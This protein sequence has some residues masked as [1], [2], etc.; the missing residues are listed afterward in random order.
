MCSEG[1]RL[2][3][4]QAWQRV[5]CGSGFPVLKWRLHSDTVF[6]C[7]SGEPEVSSLGPGGGAGGPGSVTSGGNG[8]SEAHA[9]PRIFVG[10]LTK[11]TTEDDVKQYF[12]RCALIQQARGI[13]STTLS[14]PAVAF[15]RAQMN[16]AGA[17]GSPGMPQHTLLILPNMGPPLFQLDSMQ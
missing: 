8:P 4:E 5:R 15:G 16:S 6:G 9:G 3:Q 12:T 7:L 14:L 11:G 17:H 2:Q 1:Y 10:K 13:R